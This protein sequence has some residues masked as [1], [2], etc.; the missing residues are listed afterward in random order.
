MLAETITWNQ[1]NGDI[2][3]RLTPQI[4][5]NLWYPKVNLPQ[6]LIIEFQNLS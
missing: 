4:Q 3:N 6:S 1:E 5:E 2:R